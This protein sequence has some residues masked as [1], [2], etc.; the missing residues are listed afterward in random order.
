MGVSKT[1]PGLTEMVVEGLSVRG[2]SLAAGKGLAANIAMNT[3]LLDDSWLSN[4]SNTPRS[5]GYREPVC[6]L[7][8]G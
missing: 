8:G 3:T 4:Q 1:A 5:F 7:E 2:Q 6:S